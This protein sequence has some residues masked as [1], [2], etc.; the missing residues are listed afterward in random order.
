MDQV[1]EG[2]SMNNNFSC[3]TVFSPGSRS[4]LEKQKVVC[5]ALNIHLGI[6]LFIT[7]MAVEIQCQMDTTINTFIE[8][9][10]TNHVNKSPF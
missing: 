5:I 2:D 4:G 9:C 8:E 1:Q 6:L 3:A 7:Y 10:S